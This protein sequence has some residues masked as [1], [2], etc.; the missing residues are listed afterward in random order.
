[1]TSE[2]QVQTDSIQI[3][4]RAAAAIV[5]ALICG[6]MTGTAYVVSR[7]SRIEVAIQTC[8][9]LP[10]EVAALSDR[11]STLEA[12]LAWVASE[13]DVGWPAGF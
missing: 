9:V 8:S 3:G 1:M 7:V 2:V 12:R 11:I 10:S 4:W 13:A 6:S 5:C